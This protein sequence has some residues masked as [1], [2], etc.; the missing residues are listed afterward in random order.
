MFSRVKFKQLDKTIM[1]YEGIR[2]N[3]RYWFFLN[4]KATKSGRR[5][6]TSKCKFY[7]F[8]GG[9]QSNSDSKQLIKLFIFK[10]KLNF[11]HF[12]CQSVEKADGRSLM[13]RWIGMS[14][15][16]IKEDAG[17]AWYRARDPTATAHA[18]TGYLQHRLAA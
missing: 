15:C 9:K 2:L 11:W 18:R 4:Q 12:E 14:N 5:N 3:S 7:H 1:E 13:L 6:E 16:N 8:A 10:S 17:R